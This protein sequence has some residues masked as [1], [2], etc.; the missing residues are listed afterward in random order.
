MKSIVAITL[1]LA[2]FVTAIPAFAKSGRS[3]DSEGRNRSGLSNSIAS[4]TIPCVKTAVVKREASLGTVVSTH[5]SSTASA[6]ATRASALSSAYSLTDASAIKT[7]VK[8][9]WKAFKDAIKNARKAARTG[10]KNAW[11]TFKTEVKACAGGNSISDMG[12][13]KSEGSDD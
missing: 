7:A 5:A 11:E 2:F 9:A 10:Q 1:A 13:S 4:T 8:D 12:N 6:Y 3:D